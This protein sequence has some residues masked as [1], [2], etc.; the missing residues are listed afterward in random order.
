MLYEV[1][2]IDISVM[3]YREDLLNSLPNYKTI[4]QKIDNSISWKDLINIDTEIE[5]KSH[6]LFVFPADDYEGLMCMFV[7]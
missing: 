5:R 4:K 3:Y 7:E 1:I 6:S 2:T